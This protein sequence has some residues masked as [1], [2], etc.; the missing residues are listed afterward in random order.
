MKH[1]HILSFDYHHKD[2]PKMP[3]SIAKIIAYLNNDKRFVENF[4][5]SQTSF[6]MYILNEPFSMELLKN[7]FIAI[8]AYV[9]SEK[10]VQSLLNFLKENKYSGTIILGAYEVTDVDTRKKYPQADFFIIGHA[11]KA[12]LD[13]LL[14][15]SK[16]KF[17]NKAPD[18]STISNI[19]SNKT[20]EDIKGKKVRLETKRNCPFWCTFC[21]HKDLIETN[22]KEIDFDQIITELKYLNQV[23]VKKVNVID[24]IFNVGKNYMDILEQL[25]LMKFKPKISFQVR[26]EF[27]QGK[28]GDRFLELIKQLD[29]ELEFGLQ[30]I[31]PKEYEVIERNNDKKKIKYA[32]KRLHNFNI[33]YEVSLIYG[34]PHQ[35]LNTFKDSINFLKDLS[36]KNIIA[37]P[38]M[39]LSGTALNRDRDVYAFEEEYIDGIPYVCSSNSFSKED[40]R[41]MK[42][43]ANQL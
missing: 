6:N 1:L 5:I 26:F 42:N 40:Y 11:E 9:W 15:G 30:T 19:Y 14:E 41:L 28:K 3:Y 38:L 43:F 20:I 36:C 32:I 13:L 35:T 2:E 12:L 8:A 39:L 27:I 21:A 37:Y 24:P 29:A 10:Q 25:V 4:N 34:L 18:P 33:D 22:V 23:G 31:I 17:I 7:D 16:D